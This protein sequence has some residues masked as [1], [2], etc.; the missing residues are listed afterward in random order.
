MKLKRFMINESTKNVNTML[1]FIMKNKNFIDYDF[2]VE[3]LW[4]KVAV[5]KFK[6]ETG[7]YPTVSRYEWKIAD[8]GW[9]LKNTDKMNFEDILKDFKDFSAKTPDSPQEMA[10][11]TA[12][13]HLLQYARWDGKGTFVNIKDYELNSLIRFLRYIVYNKLDRDLAE[14]NKIIDEYL[15][16]KEG[17]VRAVVDFKNVKLPEVGNIVMTRFKNGK[18]IIKGLNKK[19]QDHI[20]KIVEMVS[21]L[22]R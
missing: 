14:A 16:P 15:R 19:Q 8:L 11:K 10:E 1:D 13:T 9:E 2:Q 6:K 4:Q 5:A 12:F 20:T 3:D 7:F 17:V 18:I 21:K 22:H